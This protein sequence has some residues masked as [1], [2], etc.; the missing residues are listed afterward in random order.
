VEATGHGKV[1]LS[2]IVGGTGSVRALNWAAS[3]IGPEHFTDKVQQ[4]LFTLLLRYYGEHGGIISAAA[5][6]DLLRDQAPGTAL[7]YGEAYAAL[8]ARMP[9]KHQ[10]LH[11]VSQLRD[12]A[13]RRLTDETL[14]T[15]ALIMRQE[16]LLDDG[17]KLYGDKD[18]REYALAGFA[19]AERAAGAQDSPEGDVRTEGDDILAAYAQAKEMQ[20]TGKVAGVQ[21]GLPELDGYLDG[22]LDNGEMAI[23]VAGTSYGKSS[24]C[25]QA[26][27][28][29]AVE[30]GKNVLMFTTE[31]HRSS[32]RLKIV[33]RHSKHP[34][35]GLPRGLDAA[36]VRAGRLSPEEERVLAWVVGDLKTGGYGEIQVVQM[37]EQCSISV[38]ASRAAAVAR[39]TPPDFVVVD[40]LQQFEPDRRSRESRLVEDQSGIVKAGKRWATSFLRGRGVPLLS[41]W[42][43]NKAGADRMRAGG[44][45]ELDDL[46]QTREASMTPGLVLSLTSRE[47]DTTRGRA[48]PLELKVLKNRD[49]PRGRKFQLTADYATS[50]FTDREDLASDLLDQDF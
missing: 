2:A 24:L 32:A 23:L 16:V 45:F 1:V 31:Q 46:S 17:R 40:Y 42:Q 7:M 13:S 29:N 36:A 48:A 25:A 20:R 44:D 15:A 41:P 5:L 4:L 30:C 26:A 3:Q 47:E 35:F 10:F 8:A 14:A 50:C 21:F 22:G 9:E 19:D 38:M 18:A 34:K 28:Y 6:E 39:R 27:W 37:P 43:V 11:S 33:T 12:L 49:G